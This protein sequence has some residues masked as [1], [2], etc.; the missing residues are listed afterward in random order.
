MVFKT[1]ENGAVRACLLLANVLFFWQVTEMV[2]ASLPLPGSRVMSHWC[3]SLGL[4]VLKDIPFLDVALW[5]GTHKQMTSVER[6]QHQVDTHSLLAER[7][8][9]ITHKNDNSF[10]RDKT[11]KQMCVC[12]R[13]LT[14]LHSF[15]QMYSKTLY[16]H[17]TNYTVVVIILE[18]IT[19]ILLFI[20][21]Y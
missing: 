8:K 11:R 10:L 18:I 14:M 6:S 13:C 9:H 17:I 20:S 1:H 21:Q 4:A 5:D 3:A 15:D 2:W 12:T 7:L 19:N 16:R